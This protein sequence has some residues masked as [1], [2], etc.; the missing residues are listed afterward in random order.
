MLTSYRWSVNYHYVVLA[1]GAYTAICYLIIIS[2]LYAGWCRPFTQ[3]FLLK[4][5]VGRSKRREDTS[6]TY[7]FIG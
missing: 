3:Y 2:V 5:D 7:A 1:V 6:H 4:P